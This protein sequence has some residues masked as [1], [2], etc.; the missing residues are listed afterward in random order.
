MSESSPLARRD[1]RSHE[2]RL[3]KALASKVR[4]LRDMRGMSRKLFAQTSH[5][6]E[7]HIGR[8]EAGRGNVSILVLDRLA[9]ALGTSLES[10]LTI[11][12]DDLSNDRS[13]IIEFVRKQP[14][15]DLAAIR[16]LLLEHRETGTA[17]ERLIALVGLRGAGKSAVGAALGERL[18]M[19]FVELD[20]EIELE[21]RLSLNDIFALY[22]QTGYRALERR[23]LERVL[24]QYEEVVFA[25]GGG[26]VTDPHSYELL[27][28]SCFTVW[29]HARHHVYYD[30]THAQG[31]ERIASPA[32][33]RTAME[34]IRRTMSA[35]QK[36]YK[37]ANL[38][39]D[40]SDLS[41]EQVVSKV[42]SCIKAS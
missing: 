38:A 2:E 34:R 14:A 20:K 30:R 3:L 36:L 27:M 28:R 13:L 24:L 18:C 31:D 23:A 10:L 17:R 7:P 25:T 11:E 12:P 4:Y 42:T 5:V 26:I 41:I 33:H 6:S 16:R 39:V 35:R 22:G 19:P 9:Q 21:A 40:T 1:R 8:L 32:I 37:A 15:E 29:L